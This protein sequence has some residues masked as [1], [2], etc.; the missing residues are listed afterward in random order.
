MTPVHIQA[1]LRSTRAI[2]RLRVRP[3]HLEE[4]C[5]T[6]RHKWRC[7]PEDLARHHAFSGFEAGRNLP[8]V[9]PMIRIH[10]SKKKPDDA[11]ITVYYRDTWY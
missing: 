3:A 2:Q 1:R 6:L 11:F 10:S 8:G 5:K 9:V 4:Y 7:P